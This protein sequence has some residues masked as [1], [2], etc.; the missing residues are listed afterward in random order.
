M[1]KLIPIVF[2][3]LFPATIYS[4]TDSA[5]KGIETG[6]YEVT[7]NPGE[8]EKPVTIVIF[9]RRT[10]KTLDFYNVTTKEKF[11]TRIMESDGAGFNA[12]GPVEMAVV[13]TGDKKLPP[14]LFFA[15][16]RNELHAV[17]LSKNEQF[18]ATITSLP[19][20]WA[21]GNHDKPTHTAKTEPEI[22]E[23]TTRNGCKLWHKLSDA[24]M[25]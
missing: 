5:T 18:A 9:L 23:L 13:K 22:K 20:V 11:Q 3:I 25:K 19:S 6:F 4:Q 16:S 24:D 1:L 8:K 7:V 2:L 17:G 21:C 15:A 14:Y 12:L 10:D